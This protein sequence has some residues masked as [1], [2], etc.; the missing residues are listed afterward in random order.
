MKGERMLLF[1]VFVVYTEWVASMG[2]VNLLLFIKLDQL[3]D[4]YVYNS[5]SLLNFLRF[6]Y[7]NSEWAFAK[8]SASNFG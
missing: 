8:V 1:F 3:S 5:L 7:A 4:G 2:N 6:F